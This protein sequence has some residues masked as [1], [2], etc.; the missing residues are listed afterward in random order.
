VAADFEHLDQVLVDLVNIEGL[1]G[2][3]TGGAKRRLVRLER[4]TRLQ[5]SV[6]IALCGELRDGSRR[7]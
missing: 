1:I 2:D 6:L 3:T 4:A 5:Q 7:G